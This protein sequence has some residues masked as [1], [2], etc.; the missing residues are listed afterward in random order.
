[1]IDNFLFRCAVADELMSHGQ[2]DRLPEMRRMSLET[3]ELRATAGKNIN[4]ENKHN[5]Y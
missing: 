4:P 5:K 1:M 2:R 3:T